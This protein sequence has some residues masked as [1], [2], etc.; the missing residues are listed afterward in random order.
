MFVALVFK[1]GMR[2][3]HVVIRVLS[4]STILVHAISYTARI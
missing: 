4:G 2:M 3:R 1:H